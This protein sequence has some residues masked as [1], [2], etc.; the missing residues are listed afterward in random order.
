MRIREV[1]TVISYSF[2]VNEVTG[3]PIQSVFFDDF[4]DFESALNHAK[5]IQQNLG[6]KAIIVKAFVVEG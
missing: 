2:D 6:R 4:D 3:I 1:W 5:L